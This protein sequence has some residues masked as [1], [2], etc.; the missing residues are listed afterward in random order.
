ME[1]LADKVDIRSKIL[2]AADV[3]IAPE[4]ELALYTND[5]TLFHYL[6]IG[7]TEIPSYLWLKK[8]SDNEVKLTKSPADS[9]KSMEMD[10]LSA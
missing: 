4:D 7:Q 8:N 3:G 10:A 5:R 2:K 9:K 6:S 1:Y